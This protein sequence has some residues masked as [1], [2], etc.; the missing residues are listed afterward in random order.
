EGL[1]AATVGVLR[2]CGYEPRTDGCEVTMANCPFHA[3]AQD[4]TDLVCG[5]NLALM[6]GLLE[7]PDESVL[8]AC[9]D[10]GPDRCC[11]RL[12]AVQSTTA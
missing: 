12:R 4:F 2:D 11:V 9:P 7:G 6:R 3:L 5:M 10:P 1:V 8:E